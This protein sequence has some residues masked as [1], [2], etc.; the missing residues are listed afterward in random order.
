MTAPRSVAAALLAAALTAPGFAAEPT[1]AAAPTKLTPPPAPASVKAIAVH[2]EKLAFRSGDE[3][4][5]LVV[6]ATLADGKLADLTHAATYTLADPKAAAV[7]PAGRVTPAANGSTVLTV[8]YGDKAATVPVSAAHVGEDLPI[9]FPTPVVPVFTKLG[10][11][12]G[13]CHGMASG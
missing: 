3:A 9:N 11:N 12:S 7:T 2:P 8:R 13:G 1:P 10:C 6:T 5:Q 4:A